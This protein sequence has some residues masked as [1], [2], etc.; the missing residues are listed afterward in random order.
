[1]ATDAELKSLTE[2]VSNPHD[3]F[4]KSLLGRRALIIEFL[5]HYLP[6]DVTADFNLRALEVVK[7]SFIGE[8]LL[9]YKVKL[10][11]Q[12]KD[13][14][15]P[16]LPLVIPV[17]LYHGRRRWNIGKSFRSLV[18]GSEREEWRRYVP[19]FEYYL[20]DL[21]RYSDDEIKGSIGLQVGLMLMKYIFRRELGD[22]LEEIVSPLRQLPDDSW[23]ENFLPVVKYLLSAPTRLRP[24][25]T[26]E[27]LESAVPKNRGGIM[28]TVAEVWK[29][30]G[31]QQGLEQGLQQ[32]FKH[33]FGQISARAEKQILRLPLQLLKELSEASLDFAKS[34]DLAAWL[35]EHSPKRKP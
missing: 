20:C 5:R 8:E 21:S 18:A 25:Q 19:D 3:A 6:K 9:G 11:E 1:M 17:V 22:R 10:W 23:L 29:R 31:L 26:I 16:I 28:Q 30:E 12:A 33:R 2:E 7:D 24:E 32:G 14:G 4:F 15:S 13:T 34:S 35:R 27:K